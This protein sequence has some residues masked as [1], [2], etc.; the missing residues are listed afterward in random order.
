M[1][2]QFT[3]APPTPALPMPVAAAPGSDASVELLRQLLDVQ[4][5]HF[6]F[7][8]AQAAAADQSTRWKAFLARWNGEFPGLGAQCKKVLPT[9]ERAWLGLIDELTSRLKDQADELDNEFALAEF[10][11]R[12][13]TRIGQLGLMISQLSPL[14]DAAG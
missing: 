4:R 12:Y 3:V 10:L 8:Q 13:A 14:A 11:D 7:I 9:V 5:Q 1:H 2:F 6:G